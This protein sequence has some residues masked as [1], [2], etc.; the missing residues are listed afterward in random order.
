[1]KNRENNQREAHPSH[2]VRNF[3]YTLW[4]LLAAFCF[5]TLFFALSYEGLPYRLGFLI[6]CGAVT[7][8]TLLFG[9]A[10]PLFRR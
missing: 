5:V 4:M 1:M 8:V 7:A 6:G 10:A 3:F 9:L 2:P